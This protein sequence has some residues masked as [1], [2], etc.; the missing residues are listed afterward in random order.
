MLKVDNNHSRSLILPHPNIGPILRNTSLPNIWFILPD[1]YNA[2]LNFPDTPSDEVASS[3]LNS[4]VINHIEGSDS[5]DYETKL[6]DFVE[7]VMSSYVQIPISRSVLTG[8]SVYEVR[9]YD[10]NTIFLTFV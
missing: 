1:I 5:D 7:A 10:A 3:I 8:T 9:L 4:D 2:L 6:Y